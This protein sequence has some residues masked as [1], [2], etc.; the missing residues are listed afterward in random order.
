[1]KF[2]S[3]N[4]IVIA[5]ANTGKANNNK[6]VVIK[7]DQENKDINSIF[8]HFCRIIIIDDKKFKE[9][10]IEEAPAK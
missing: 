5:P 4:N 9:L 10:I 1:L 3:V 2:R 7:I 8:I 6:N